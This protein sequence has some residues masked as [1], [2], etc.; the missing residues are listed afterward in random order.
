M[1]SSMTKKVLGISLFI[2]QILDVGALRVNP[3]KIVRPQSG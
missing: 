3:L 1:R 2:I